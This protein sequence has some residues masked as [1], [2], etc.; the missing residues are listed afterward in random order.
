M[1]IHETLSL[2][3]PTAPALGFITRKQLAHLPRC[4]H[5]SSELLPFLCT[6]TLPRLS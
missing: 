1:S 3:S 4:F 5:S 6:Y 2:L